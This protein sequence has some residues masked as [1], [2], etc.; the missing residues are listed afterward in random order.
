VLLQPGGIQN[1]QLQSEANLKDGVKDGLG[2]RWYENGQLEFEANYKNGE[3]D[4]LSKE[5]DENG[6]R[7]N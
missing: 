6:Q 7:T 3:I 4:G 1:G 2:K 5:W